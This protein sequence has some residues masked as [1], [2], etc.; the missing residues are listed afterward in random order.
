[1]K[2]KLHALLRRIFIKPTVPWGVFFA[3]IF[4]AMGIT[5]YG[6][7]KGSQK[8]ETNLLE[9]HVLGEEIVNREVFFTVHSV[10]HDSK[11]AGP[12]VPKKGN[13]FL[14]VMFTLY[15]NSN[16]SFDFAPLLHFHVKD[17]AG[18]IYGVVA[19][20][21]STEQLPGSISPH[22]KLREEVGF[23]VPKNARGLTLYFDPHFDSSSLDPSIITVDLSSGGFWD[24]F[25]R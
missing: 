14:G 18:N 5:W 9:R 19:I 8:Q 22:D 2:I 10:R 15:N 7:T 25:I 21:N 11:G 3:F 12:L 4:I 16:K 23:E 1:M 13:E 17:D 6:F 20:P 24:F